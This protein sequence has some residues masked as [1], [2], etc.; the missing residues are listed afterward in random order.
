MGGDWG[1]Y[2]RGEEGRVGAGGQRGDVCRGQTLEEFGRVDAVDR[3]Q[4]ACWR[5]FSHARGRR[6]GRERGVWPPQ[7]GRTYVRYADSRGHRDGYYA[8]STGGTGG[9][10]RGE[11]R[12]GV[13]GG[14][15]AVVEG[16]FVMWRGDEMTLLSL[17]CRITVTNH[18]S[19]RPMISDIHTSF[20]IYS[21]FYTPSHGPRIYI[22][23]TRRPPF[24]PLPPP[25]PPPPLHPPPRPSPP[26]S[27]HP[28]PA[29][30]TASY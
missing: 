27:S 12:G 24:Y 14:E 19:A 25:P 10:N 2:L 22:T 20:R 18:H 29:S 26:P 8:N 6:V 30:S 15:L 3:N 23:P 11:G 7:T 28:S 21:F 1:A 16:D 17:Q 9:E 5:E 13:R 4:L